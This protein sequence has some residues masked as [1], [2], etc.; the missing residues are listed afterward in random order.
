M[1]R[2]QEA[3]RRAQEAANAPLA[4]APL[5]SATEYDVETLAREAFPSEAAS[6]EVPDAELPAPA[7]AVG[8]DLAAEEVVAANPLPVPPAQTPNGTG[9]S[10][11]FDNLSPAMATKVVTDETMQPASREQYRKLAAALHAAQ[12]VNQI[13]VAMIA[14]AV[15]GEGKTLTATNLALTLSESYQ[16]NVLLIDADLRRPSLYKV[17]QFE[18]SPGLVDTLMSQED[19]KLALHRVTP[20]LTVLGAG[21]PSSDPMAGLTSERM[22]RLLAEAREVFDW[23]IIDTPPVGLL[24]DANLMSSMVDAAILVVRADATPY[25]LVQRAVEAV[26]KERVLGVV[27][28]SA[29]QELPAYGYHYY[30]AYYGATATHGSGK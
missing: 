3:M 28:N 8:A 30:H 12:Q 17:F 4:E 6:P 9:R 15:A 21:K 13:K 20:R 2:V 23:I 14:S 19:G 22:R 27:L 24:T 10:S 1:G 25:F 7:L 29:T 16:R 18:P 26:G 11:I 5:P